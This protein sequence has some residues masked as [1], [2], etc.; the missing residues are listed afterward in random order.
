MTRRQERIK[1]LI[2][3]GNPNTEITR[4]EI[5]HQHPGS[6]MPPDDFE[7]FYYAQ[8]FD[9]M[10]EVTAFCL[11]IAAASSAIDWRVEE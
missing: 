3:R 8:K 11:G 9:T 4:L 6:D 2:Q 1:A 10:D 5:E 7:R